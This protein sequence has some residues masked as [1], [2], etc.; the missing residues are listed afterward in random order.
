MNS[1]KP[2]LNKL[3]KA[4]LIMLLMILSGCNWYTS[5]V[6]ISSDKGSQIDSKA[7]GG[8]AIVENDSL[9]AAIDIEA[10]DDKNYIISYVELDHDDNNISL[11]ENFAAHHSRVKNFDYVNLRILEGEDIG[12]FYFIR[13]EIEGDSLFFSTLDADF[14]QE[15]TSSRKFKKY[16]E[17]NQLKFNELFK[18]TLKFKKYELNRMN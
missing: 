13:Y 6:P 4:A 12:K 9:M 10:Y 11:L 8:W 18:D 1:I 15:F 16:I 2:T 5:T 17:K 14:D 7:L 3:I